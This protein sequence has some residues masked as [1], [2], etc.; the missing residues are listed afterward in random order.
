MQRFK[1]SKVRKTYQLQ[2]ASPLRQPSRLTEL[3]AQELL[4]EISK[5]E[6]QPSHHD[7]YLKKL[8]RNSTSPKRYNKPVPAPASPR[9]QETAITTSE[10]TRFRETFHANL[11]KPLNISRDLLRQPTSSCSTAGRTAADSQTWQLKRA[12]EA[13]PS[14]S[15]SRRSGRP[16]TCSVF[17]TAAGCHA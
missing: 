16:S 11:P 6:E 4:I 17:A 15:I 10:L 2:E 3:Q 1:S 8:T 14:Q 13:T 9:K 5:L 12:N 7:N